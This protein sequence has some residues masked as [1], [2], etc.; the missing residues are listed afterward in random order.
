[1]LRAFLE[2]SFL[3]RLS[4]FLPIAFFVFGFA[5]LAPKVGFNLFPG[6]DNSV[7][8]FTIEGGVG[9]TTDSFHPKLAKIP[10]IF[11]KYPE[12]SFFKID[13]RGNSATAYVQLKKLPER[14]EAR[15]RGVFDIEKLLL[16]DF[17]A[18]SGDGLRIESKV[19]KG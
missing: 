3:R 15:M 2:S 10:A 9:E 18:I 17:A 8:S 12:I 14:K 1:M 13:T 19:Q 16:A 7:I 5:V 11:G 4:I 6:T